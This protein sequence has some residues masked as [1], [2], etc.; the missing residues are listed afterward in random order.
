MMQLK[1]YT[2][3]IYEIFAAAAGMRG[4]VIGC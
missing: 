2:V 1:H 4:V 3:S